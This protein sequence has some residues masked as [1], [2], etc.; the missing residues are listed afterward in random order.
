MI[1]GGGYGGWEGHKEI[2]CGFG[3]FEDRGLKVVMDREGGGFQAGLLPQ[4]FTRLTDG[5]FRQL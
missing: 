4:H 5:Q 3:H 1:V 2:F